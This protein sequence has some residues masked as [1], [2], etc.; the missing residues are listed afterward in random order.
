M[1][2]P[3]N[4][5]SVTLTFTLKSGFWQLRLQHCRVGE[6]LEDFCATMFFIPWCELISKLDEYIKQDVPKGLIDK[7]RDEIISAF[8]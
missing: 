4:L 1:E 5:L 8:R 7:A 2:S 6:S 3:W